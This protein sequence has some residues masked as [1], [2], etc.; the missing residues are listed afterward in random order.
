M[1]VLKIGQDI[2]NTD[3]ILEFERILRWI[4]HFIITVKRQYTFSGNPCLSVRPRILVVHCGKKSI[5]KSLLF[6]IL[7]CKNPKYG[8]GVSITTSL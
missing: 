2:K 1:L 8:P 6:G 4:F 3:P 7:L 5:L